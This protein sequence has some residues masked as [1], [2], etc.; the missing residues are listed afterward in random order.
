MKIR[1]FKPIWQCNGYF[2]HNHKT[3]FGALFCRNIQGII[4]M[5]YFHLW[6]LRKFNKEKLAK[7]MM[8]MHGSNKRAMLRRIKKGQKAI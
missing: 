6:Y 3:E 2:K 5:E 1:L 7:I 8:A 4:P